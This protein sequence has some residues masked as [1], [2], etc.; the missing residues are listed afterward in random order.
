[1]E[2]GI[3]SILP[4]KPPFGRE[5]GQAVQGLAG[6]FPWPSETGIFPAQS[7]I[8]SAESGIV[9]KASP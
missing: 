1:V 9:G 7:G 8:K 4:S 6:E 2:P 5:N 3:S